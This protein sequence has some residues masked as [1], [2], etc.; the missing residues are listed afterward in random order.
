[1]KWGWGHTPK[2]PT[3]IVLWLWTVS[4]GNKKK[5][6]TSLGISLRQPQT[7]TKVKTRK[8][9]KKPTKT[10]I[11]GD[12][13]MKWGWE[14]K[15]QGA[16]SSPCFTWRVGIEN[17]TKQ[18]S[19]LKGRYWKKKTHCLCGWSLVLGEIY[20]KHTFIENSQLLVLLWMNEDFAA[21]NKITWLSIFLMTKKPIWIYVWNNNFMI[22][23]DIPNI[24]D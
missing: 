23:Q 19:P 18:R 22:F 14:H 6:R 10:V 16:H 8:H 12:G 24:K 17:K 13:W 5:K 1:M 15:P 20:W 4:I 7:T 11:W 3:T 9:H 2:E 21:I